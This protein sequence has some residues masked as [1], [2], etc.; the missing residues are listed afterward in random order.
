MLKMPLGK[1]VDRLQGGAECELYDIPQLDCFPRGQAWV[2]SCRLVTGAPA[3]AGNRS[4]PAG[5][6]SGNASL[7]WAFAEAA[8]R[9]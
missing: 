4:G 7:Q 2:A 6:Q 9:C 8:V 1:Y 5:Q 3:A